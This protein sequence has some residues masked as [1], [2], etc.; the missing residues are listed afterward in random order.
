[1]LLPQYL[2]HRPVLQRG[3]TLLPDPP[4]PRLQNNSASPQ[5]HPLGTAAG[6]TALVPCSMTAVSQEDRMKAITELT[7]AAM[8]VVLLVAVALKIDHAR[9]GA[10]ASLVEKIHIIVDE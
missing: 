2:D 7:V 9:A 3:P 10:P 8:A 5:G 6:W 4:D 1:V